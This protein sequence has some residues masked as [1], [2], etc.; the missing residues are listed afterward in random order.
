MDAHGSAAPWRADAPAAK[1]RALEERLRQL[2]ATLR[3]LH[4]RRQEAGERLRILEVFA[5]EKAQR[6]PH[7][8]RI[9]ALAAARQVEPGDPYLVPLEQ[10]RVDVDK[11]RADVE[12]LDAQEGPLHARIRTL[13]P[14][15]NK[16]QRYMERREGR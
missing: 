14:L 10:A 16:C 3:D 13:G 2:H 6:L 5:A 9:Q 11:A 7:V 15:V 4:A 1:L 12:W 8:P